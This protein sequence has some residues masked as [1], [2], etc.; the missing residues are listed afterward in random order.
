MSVDER[1]LRALR[2]MD[3][4]EPGPDLFRR[5]VHSI[6]EDR[7]HR[8]RVVRTVVTVSVVV[9]ALVGLGALSLDESTWGTHVVPWRFALLQLVGLT[10]LAVALGPAIRRFGR[11]YADDLWPHA[12]VAARQL[13][14]LLDVAYGL[15]VAGYILVT[16]E[17]PRDGLPWPDDVLAQQLST[18]A[19]RAGGLLLLLGVLHG[20]TLVVL[21]VLALVS[22]S[23]RLGRRLPRWLSVGLIVA[24]VMVLWQ[25]VGGALAL[26]MAGLG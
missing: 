4:V 11:G 24:G 18:A 2:A 8:R 1:V 6:E 5:V 3:S 13:I 26:L 25:A 16:T 7:R 22:N 23:T 15:V 10:S 20:V 9:A 17:I 19:V 21:P 14:R 12:D